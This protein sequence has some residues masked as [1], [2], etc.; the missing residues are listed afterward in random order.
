MP[1]VIAGLLVV[2]LAGCH[3]SAQ[4]APPV[5]SLPR[6]G[7]V[8]TA[9]PNR[10][11]TCGAVGFRVHFDWSVASERRA[12][13]YMLRVDSPTGAVLAAGGREGHVDTGDWAQ[14]GQWF[15]LVTIGSDEV[16]AAVRIGPDDCG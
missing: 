15:F 10:G 7:V 14:A 11:P 4:N 12:D 6:P 8:L 5:L 1:R 16:V 13:K 3:R 2:L 9:T